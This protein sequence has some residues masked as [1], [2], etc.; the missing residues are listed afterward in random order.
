MGGCFAL[1]VAVDSS[2]RVWQD[3]V[4]VCMTGIKETLDNKLRHI[5]GFDLGGEIFALSFISNN[6]KSRVLYLF[7]FPQTKQDFLSSGTC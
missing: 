6:R 2:N 5:C 7:T 3:E 4:L 1:Y